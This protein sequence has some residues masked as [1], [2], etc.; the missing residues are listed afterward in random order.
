MTGGSPYA[1]TYSYS[2]DA[3]FNAAGDS[4]TALTVNPLPLILSGAEPY[5]GSATAPFGYLTIANAIN[6]DDVSLA[7]GAASLAGA[8]AGPEGDCL[9]RFAGFG[10][11]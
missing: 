2:G 11:A 3:S 6:G 4:S 9:R 5:S 8:A 1:I 7:S 10:R